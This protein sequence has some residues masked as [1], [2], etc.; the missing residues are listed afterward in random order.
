MNLPFTFTSGTIFLSINEDLDELIHTFIYYEVIFFII[1]YTADALFLIFI[2]IMITS[3]EKNKN[4]L[5]FIKKILN[6]E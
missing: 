4:I 2:I 3:N 1:Y 5:V 6:K